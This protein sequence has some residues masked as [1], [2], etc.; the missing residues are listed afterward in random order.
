MRLP[1]ASGAEVYLYDPGASPD[2]LPSTPRLDSSCSQRNGRDDMCCIDDGTDFAGFIE[3][4]G[5]DLPDGS[6]FRPGGVMGLRRPYA[7]GPIRQPGK[8]SL[9]SPSVPRPFS[10]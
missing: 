3:A 4:S 8:E 10:P 5:G 6:R 1:E 9:P 2:V 7:G